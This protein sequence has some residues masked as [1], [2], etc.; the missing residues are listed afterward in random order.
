MEEEELLRLRESRHRYITPGCISQLTRLSE[1]PNWRNLFVSSKNGIN[2]R[3]L[4]PSKSPKQHRLMEAVAH[5][6]QFAKKVK[7]PQSVGKEFAA[8][9][10]AKKTSK[11]AGKPSRTR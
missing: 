11:P 2:G 1:L 8:A 5:N 6:P 9:D 3:N 7:I 4:M 10:A